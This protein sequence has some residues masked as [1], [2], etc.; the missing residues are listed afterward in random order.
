MAKKE[1]S[2]V[3]RARN[4]MAAGLASAYNSLKSLGAGALK[5]GK[6]IGAGMLA[7]VAAV[8][9]FAV[10][11]L[12]AYATQ[13]KAVKSLESAINSYGESSKKLLPGLQAV[14]SAIQ[15]ETGAADESTLAT[16]ARLKILGVQTERLGEAAK[17]TIAL[18]SVGMEEAAAAKAVAMAMQGQYTMLNRYVPALRNA[19]SETEKAAIVN[20]LFAKGYQ[21]QKDL[22]KTTSGAWM[23]LKGRIGD[24]LESI[25][26]AIDKSAGLQS[27][28]HTAGEAVKAFGQRISDWVNSDRFKEIQ[29]SIGGIVNAM[30][31]GGESRSAMFGA[32]ADLVLAS[33]AV[34]AERAANVLKAA[35]PLIGKLIGAGARAVIEAVKPSGPTENFQAQMDLGI[36]EKTAA[37]GYRK[38]GFLE[39]T[40]DQKTAIEQQV[41]LNREQELF[42]SLGLSAK[43]IT[44]DQTAAEL[45]YAKAKEKVVD[46]ME[47]ANAQAERFQEYTD[48]TPPPVNPYANPELDAALAGMEISTPEELA[49]KEEDFKK[50]EVERLKG[51]EDRAVKSAEDAAEEASR[52]KGLWLSRD[53][54]AAEKA[55]EKQRAKEQRQ[56]ENFNKKI[57][58][59]AFKRGRLSGQGIER[60][61]AAAAAEQK[62]RDDAA[63]AT[64]AKNAREAAEKKMA[65]DLG[66][67]EKNTKDLADKMDEIS[68]LA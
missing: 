26:E 24:A 43:E 20:D 67:I 29:E 39:L 61:M 1:I 21:Q 30:K 28:L 63:A 41:K 27:I 59:G 3:I 36:A 62:A 55:A 52:V 14:A 22:L 49:K 64:A 33:F 4:A 8:T 13:Q 35:A 42:N 45:R 25:G 31:Q 57:N 50:A 66:K 32:M 54:R 19:T 53:A 9:A 16:M 47:K 48:V 34:A 6:W 11:A 40:A 17:A 23:A 37:G 18:K 2:I 15:D 38:L 12:S 65:E 10:K 58:S 46:L 56:I 51:I 5:I 60:G 68:E 44:E 7:G